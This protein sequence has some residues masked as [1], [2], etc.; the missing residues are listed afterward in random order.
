M[1]HMN[2][3][4]SKIKNRKLEL[5]LFFLVLIFCIGCKETGRIDYIDQSAPP[6]T[7][8]E[9][10]HVRNTN[11]GAVLKYIVP[12]DNNLLYVQAVYEIRPGVQRET[13]AS[14]Y[15][16]SLV[17]E[18]FGDTR[19]YEVK[20]YSVG[21]NGKQSEPLI[22]TV[23]P[24]IAPLHMA[25]V[26]MRPTFG[27]VSLWIENPKETNLAI[28][29]TGD[30]ANLGYHVFLQTFYTSREKVTFN[31]RGLSSVPLEFAVHLRDRWNNITA[32]LDSTLTPIQE[33]FIP[34]ATWTE[35]HLPTDSYIAI[36][37]N[38]P[39][40][41]PSRAWDNIINN[42]DLMWAAAI[43]SPFPQWITWDMGLTAVIGRLKV[44]HRGP[45]NR[46]WENQ[47]RNIK[48][49]ELWGS[50]SPNLDGSW[51]D[52]WIPLGQFECV[53]PS[54]EASPTDEDHYYA[55][56]EGIDFDLI[57]NEFSP[58]PFQPVRYIRFVAVETFAGPQLVGGYFLSEIS[59]WGMVEE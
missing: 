17:L 24:L 55:N 3:R 52:S 10:L 37:N 39:A 50:T 2:N 38:N 45:G 25:S 29:L 27:G 49:F 19:E 8:I 9:E 53:R 20:I 1:N 40:F 56:V 16:D 14:F 21:K 7:Q 54:G 12:D 23:H 18:G 34:K 51:D 48:K 44:W 46:A 41:Q 58:D 42:Q 22:E 30:T 47:E 32:T 57:P 59:F 6:P 15:V 35:V 4:K 13:K 36:E 43:T 26:E 11:G 5:G 28:V 33:Q 31:Y